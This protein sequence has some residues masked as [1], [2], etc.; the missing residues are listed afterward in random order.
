MSD[1]RSAMILLCM[2][3]AVCAV[4]AQPAEPPSPGSTTLV[5]DARDWDGRVV[6]FTGE[7]IGEAM[8]R[9]PMAWIH[10]NDDAYGLADRADARLSGSNGGIGVWIDSRLASRIA[11]FGDYAHHGDL[12]EVSGIFHAA[13]TQH[14]GDMDIHGHT[15]RIARPGYEVALPIGRPRLRAAGMLVALTALLFLARAILRRQGKP[16]H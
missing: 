4:S 7:A 16:G 9:G 8:R 12:I 13:C 15:L 1:T 14:G 3:A 2:L 6:T 10:L 11:L 5:E